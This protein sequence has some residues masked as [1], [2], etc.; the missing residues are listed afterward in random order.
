MPPEH[1]TFAQRYKLTPTE[2]RVSV[3]IAEVGGIPEVAD[4][5]GLA[6]NTVRTHLQ[7]VF[8]KTDI[9]RQAELV[10]LVAS[11]ASPLLR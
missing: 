8:L 1:R 11:L 7:R 2:A 6:P 4:A 10:K 5:L 9:H 3:A